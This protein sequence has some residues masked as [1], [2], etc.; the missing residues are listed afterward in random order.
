MAL[1]SRILLSA[2]MACCVLP[3]VLHATTLEVDVSGVR[4]GQGFVRAA[5]CSRA[6]F[7]TDNCEYFADA[8]AVAG[9][10]VLRVP[11]V[12]PGV[13]AVQVFHD[14]TGRGV[15]HQGLFGIP[16]EGIGFSND[17]HL[18]LRG[19]KFSEATITAAGPTT[20]IAL[21]LR[22]LGSFRPTEK[23]LAGR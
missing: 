9:E 21:R 6:T 3:L 22:Y 16:R 12:V 17:A 7:L 19:P 2:A 15:I 8:T 5:V 20:R 1:R 10:T 4:S 13:Y 11:N 23:S 14:D 18:H